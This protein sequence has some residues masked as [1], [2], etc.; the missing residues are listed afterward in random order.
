VTPASSTF[1]AT[2]AIIRAPASK[3]MPTATRSPARCVRRFGPSTA[4]G[5][6]TRASP[7]R[8]PMAA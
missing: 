5:R 3:R 8:S 7:A 6:R 4:S 1:T 2:L